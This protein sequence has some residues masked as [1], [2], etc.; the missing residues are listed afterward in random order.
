MITGG[1]APR[2]DFFDILQYAKDLDFKVCIDHNL[3][4][5]SNLSFCKKVLAIDPHSRF[6]VSLHAPVAQ[7]HDSITQV[8]GSWNETLHGIKNLTSLGC[9]DITVVFVICKMNYR[10]LPEMVH[11][12]K[13]LNISNLD[14]VLV[15]KEGRAQNRYPSLVP[16]FREIEAYLLK[17]LKEA[18]L[19]GIRV[20]VTGIPVCILPNPESSHELD[21]YVRNEVVWSVDGDIRE[22]SKMAL[23]RYAK[24]EYCLRCR[25][26]ALC[27]G[28]PKE[29]FELYGFEG[30]HPR[31]GTLLRS[32][33]D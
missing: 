22:Q 18:C 1:S 7:I 28:I 30:I 4:I 13:N 10:Y 3:R 14:F 12:L 9:K 31:R 21:M 15:R 2:E 33:R 32:F 8:S 20:S 17:S 26:F 27:L 23:G 6:S 5:F 19:K 11:F 29:Y 16:T 24:S 25:Y